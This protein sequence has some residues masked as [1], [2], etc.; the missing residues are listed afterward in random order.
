M[1]LKGF[2][3][4]CILSFVSFNL[5]SQNKITGVITDAITNFPIDKVSI[6]DRDYGL[7]ATYLIQMGISSLKLKKRAS[8]NILYSIIMKFLNLIL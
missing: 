6:F 2:K 5:V 4:L 1:K 3:L 7:L 8:F